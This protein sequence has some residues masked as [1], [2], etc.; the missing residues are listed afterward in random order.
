M[1][2]Y[3]LAVADTL[4]RVYGKGAAEHAAEIGY[5]LYQAGTSA[6]AFRTATLLGQAARN[7]LAVGAFEQA[8]RL[9]DSTLQLL[10]ADR[11]R[12]RADAL[13][14]RGQAQWGL[15]RHDDARSAWKGAIERYEELS[16]ASTVTAMHR[17]IAA[18][19]SPRQAGDDNGAAPEA[20]VELQPEKDRVAGET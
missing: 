14:T 19:E 6:D 16:D 11:I 5:H 13:A 18:L 7:A 17:R 20:R 12:E 3:H 1:Q 15:G 2:A 4:E 8:L 10:P 9:I